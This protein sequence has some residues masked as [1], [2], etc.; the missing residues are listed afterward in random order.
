MVNHAAL[1]NFYIEF[2]SEYC[3][4]HGSRK[5][6]LDAARLLLTTGERSHAMQICAGIEKVHLIF[7]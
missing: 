3:M 1:L 6:C 4:T 2:L 5:A 7:G